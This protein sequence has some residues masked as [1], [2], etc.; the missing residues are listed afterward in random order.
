MFCLYVMYS[1]KLVQA[2]PVVE[3]N[4]RFKLHSHDASTVSKERKLA[5]KFWKIKSTVS[6]K[7]LKMCSRYELPISW[8]HCE[9]TL[10]AFWK[11]NI[12]V[13]ALSFSTRF[14]VVDSCETKLL[15]K[16]TRQIRGYRTLL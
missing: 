8:K 14:F 3:R 10:A 11:I 16:K 1:L 7:R 4:K 12:S 9:G 5:F 6:Y 2:K 15:Y 13:K